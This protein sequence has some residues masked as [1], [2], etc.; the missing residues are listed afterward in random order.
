[1]P[2]PNRKLGK[3]LLRSYE[4]VIVHLLAGRSYRAIAMLMNV[5]EQQV[6]R[7]TKEQEFISLYNETKKELLDSMKDAVIG[8]TRAAVKVVQDALEEHQASPLDKLP[9]A[10]YTIDLARD[11]AKLIKTDDEDDFVPVPGA[12]ER[13][14][15]E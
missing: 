12:D 10:K 4:S 7:W 11:F 3:R 5:D 14:D 13:E 15:E 2:S 9:A 6:R 1:M 8:A